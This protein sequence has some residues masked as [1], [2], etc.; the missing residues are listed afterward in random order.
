MSRVQLRNLDLPTTKAKVFYREA[1]P[2]TAPVILL[3]HG[4]PSSSH[5]YRNLIPIL[6]TKYRV[7]APDLPGFGFT[8]VPAG[9]QY[10]FDNL[11]TV[12]F[13]FLETLS[14]T[15][16]SV[17]IFD[18]GAPTGLRLALQRPDAVQAIIT[19]NGNAYEEGLGEFWDQVRELWNSNND[20]NVRSKLT[21]GLLSLEAT[22][23]QYEEG[24]Q[25]S[26]VIAPESYTLD[27]A[28]LQRPGNADIQI[29][30]FWDY[31]TNLL[32]YPKFQEY[33]RKSQVPVLAVWGKNDQI[34]IA[35]G[36]E[37]FKRDSPNAEV[38]L[39]DAGHFAVESET[40]E[41]GLLILDFLGKNG[42]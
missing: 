17:Y 2:K 30:L 25:S 3:L 26:R 27:Y 8:E 19:Q 36:A 11:A 35:P 13:D 22:K 16:F 28:L 39:L 40:E 15:R 10:T 33:F 18:Y 23:W 7:L 5:Q 38:H 6:A 41:I 24:T 42:I 9:F 21:K 20:S 31:Q 37:A 14:V 12:V 32:L 34:F 29:D 4:F 1:G